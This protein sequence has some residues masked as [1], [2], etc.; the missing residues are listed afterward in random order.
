RLR[1]L[2]RE[3]VDAADLDAVVAM[4][5]NELHRLHEGNIARFGLRLSEFGAWSRAVRHE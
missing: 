5:M 2:G 4:A 1:Q 3:I